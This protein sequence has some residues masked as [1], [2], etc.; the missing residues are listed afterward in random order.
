MFCGSLSASADI[1]HIVNVWQ[2]LWSP[3]QDPLWIQPF[4]S[5]TLALANGNLG[6]KE[7]ASPAALRT[8]LGRVE[9]FTLLLKDWRRCWDTSALTKS[10]HFFSEK[11][12]SRVCH[13]LKNYLKT[14]AFSTPRWGRINVAAKKKRTRQETFLKVRR[15]RLGSLYLL[16]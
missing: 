15:H 8:S 12:E 7:C 10:W 16:Y 14:W 3:K 13:S 6:F 9:W 5:H 1:P 4:C 11:S 2:N